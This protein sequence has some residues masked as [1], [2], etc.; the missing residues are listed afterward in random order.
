MVVLAQLAR[1]PMAHAASSGPS[2][3]HSTQQT[4]Q[5]GFHT[6]TT[7]TV[8]DMAKLYG[9]QEATNPPLY[10]A[11]FNFGGLNMTHACDIAVT[12][13]WVQAVQSQGWKL[14]PNW[15]DR[16]A[17]RDLSANANCYHQNDLEENMSAN[18]DTAHQQGI[19]AATAAVAAAQGFGI[20]P[21]SILTVDIEGYDTG[22]ATCDRAVARFV[23]GWVETLHGANYQAQVYESVPNLPALCS[24]SSALPDAV[25][26]AATDGNPSQSDIAALNT[27]GCWTNHQRLHQYSYNATTQSCAITLHAPGLS[28]P[29]V[30]LSSADGPVSAPDPSYLPSTPTGAGGS[31]HISAG[32]FN[33]D[34]KADLALAYHYQNADTGL[35]WE[36]GT[37]NAPAN[38]T[39]VWDSGVGAF[40]WNKAKVVAG[41][42]N[43]DG[44]ADVAFFY[45]NGNADTALYW[46]QGTATGLQTTPTYTL[47]WD[48]GPGNFDWSAAKF[49]AGDFNGD[50]YTDLAALY[51]YGNAR[52]KLFWMPG[53]AAGPPTSWDVT[54]WDSGVGNFD[55]TAAKFVAG[56]LNGD[57]FTDLAAFYNYGNAR[58]QLFWMRG[59]ASGLETSWT[60]GWDSG[61][62]NFDWNAARFVAGDFNG[63]GYVDLAAL[64]NY[65]NADTQLFWMPGAA[66][67][68]ESSW[69]LGWRS[70]TGNFDWTK[71]KFVAGDVNGD[72]YADIAAYYNY[73]NAET[74][75]F[76]LPVTATG[77]ETS[78]DVSGWDS[79]VGN[80]DWNAI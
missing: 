1:L 74:K 41:D 30:C 7:P 25:H 56:D 63:D 49:V 29:L 16:Q 23:N 62:G 20:R 6:C 10:W 61:A 38:P 5:G 45:N 39:S 32:D 67:G 9:Y 71:A 18:A 34:G 24:Y 50:G 55:W 53:T 77:P 80:F 22:N 14:V 11:S 42:F 8:S 75:L 76:W 46:E 12:P 78:W 79:G 48:S 54:G 15:Y 3:Y 47:V 36:Q 21:Q 59:T 37:A 73:G 70:G 27:G 52:T 58:T 31:D 64:Y 72:G 35:F 69:R 2:F 57:G 33:H 43:G 44:Y 40:D 65:G 17:P 66:S 28:Q 26:I 19:E 4:Q 68:P 51:N 13:S 60:V